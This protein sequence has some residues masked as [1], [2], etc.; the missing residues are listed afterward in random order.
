MSQLNEHN[1]FKIYLLNILFICQLQ[2]G[3]DTN[4]IEE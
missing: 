4:D 1:S 3:R 2:K